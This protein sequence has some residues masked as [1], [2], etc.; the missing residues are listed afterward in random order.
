MAGL[1][2][3]VSRTASLKLHGWQ[4][5]ASEDES[6]QQVYG[7]DLPH[8][9]QICDERPALAE[10]LHRDLPFRKA[11][12]VWAAQCE[13]ARTVE[14]VLARR[15]RALFLD[16]RASIEA[17]SETAR[18]LAEVLDRPESWQREQIAAFRG[19]AEEYIWHD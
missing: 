8:I 2:A 6:W 3:S 12:V 13:M 16:A 10:L 1:G 9:L 15:T 7:S 11:E 14:D 19:I 18:L 4:E 17:A 5:R